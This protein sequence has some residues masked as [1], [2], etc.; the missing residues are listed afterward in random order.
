VV[1]PSQRKEMAQAA[2]SNKAISVRLACQIFVVSETCYRYQPK[3]SGENAVIADLLVRLTHNQRNWGFGLCYLYLRNVKGFQWNHKRVYRI[4]R[5]LELNLR[6]KPKKRLVRQKPE[7]LSVPEAINDCW[8]MD[9]MHDQLSDSRSYRLFNVIDDFNREG[10]AIEVD[11]SLPASRVIRA[12]DQVIEWRG[13]PNRI[14]CDNGPEYISNLL[15]DW[16][17]S[18]G[19]ELAFIQ[20]G[21]PQQNAYVERYNR[22]V[23]YDWLNHYLFE[24]IDEVQRH[25]TN[26][27]WTYNNERPNMALNGITPMMKLAAA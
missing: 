2:V 3:L 20:P 23:R 15:G 19:I 9:F 24:S 22:T 17:K 10:L 25:A 7:P 5:E 21:N 13:K 6:I 8:S 16:A 1:K 18:N 4:Y 12:L 26:W 14:R 27:L 11:F